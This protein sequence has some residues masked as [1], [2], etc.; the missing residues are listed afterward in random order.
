MAFKLPTSSKT[1]N[2]TKKRVF[3]KSYGYNSR[4]YN[5]FSF[6]GN[7]IKSNENFAVGLWIFML[8][9]VKQSFGKISLTVNTCF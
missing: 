2:S 3:I 8:E 6:S 5:Q 9:T 1:K 7:I 4:S